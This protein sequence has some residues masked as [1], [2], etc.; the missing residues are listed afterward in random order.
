MSWARPEDVFSIS[1]ASYL[2]GELAITSFILLVLLLD[3]QK[4][5]G[6]LRSFDK[7]ASV[8]VEGACEQV[9]VG[10]L[11]CDIPLGLYVIRGDNIV[12]V[13]ELD[14]EGEN[15]PIDPINVSV[16]EIRRAQQVERDAMDVK[17]CVRKR[18]EFLYV[19]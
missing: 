8:V 11:Y 4:I 7:F 6:I 2:D 17:G 14:L 1:L 10:D 19:D 16:E 5:T 13:G 18:M 12:L 3:G 15:L 9:I